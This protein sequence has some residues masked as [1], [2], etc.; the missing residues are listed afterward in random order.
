MNAPWSDRAQARRRSGFS[1][2]E[3]LV[4]LVLFAIIAGAA[5][6]SLRGQQR[7]LRGASE[8]AEM[9]SQLRQAVHLLP[10]E[11]RSIAPTAGDIHA[12]SRSAVAFRA[13]S[14]SSI[15]CARL[16]DFILAIPS[17]GEEGAP[18]LTSWLVTPRAGDSVLILDP[19][20]AVGRSDDQWRLH[21]VDGIAWSQS[22]AECGPFAAPSGGG[23]LRVQVSGR[24][25]SATIAAGGAVRFFRPVRYS[26]YRGGD[27]RWYL[28]G[29]ECSAAR[30]P[31][32]SVIQPVSGPYRALAREDAESGLVLSYFDRE[33][34]T[35]DPGRDDPR[36]VGSIGVIVRADAGSWW[37]KAGHTVPLRDSLAFLVAIRNWHA[38]A[39]PAR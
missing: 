8:L 12:W 20:R 37:K 29:S 5:T 26:L 1:V 4:V 17:R 14:G 27:S 25:L 32:C 28:G 19:G 13:M 11:L 6:R 39:P 24:P 3:L 16:S 21:E 34:R 35:L 38:P 18:A 31:S 15:I 22:A 2:V 36:R 33:G 23:H 30:T 9:R 10:A 7:F